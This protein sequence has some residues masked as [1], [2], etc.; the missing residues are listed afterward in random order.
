MSVLILV[1]GLFQELKCLFS[2]YQ[3]GQK[4]LMSTP[5]VITFRPNPP[6]GNEKLDFLSNPIA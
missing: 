2:Y 6:L 3:H 1:L 4:K 5:K